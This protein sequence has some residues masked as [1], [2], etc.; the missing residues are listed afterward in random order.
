MNKL[1]FFLFLKGK[2]YLRAKTVLPASESPLKIKKYSD[3]SLHL[4]RGEDS[5]DLFH[6]RSEILT[7]FSILYMSLMDIYTLGRLFRN[8]KPPIT[9]SIVYVGQLHADIYNGFMRYMKY[10]K[11]IDLGSPDIV[12]DI[13]QFTPN[14]KKESFLFN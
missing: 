11:V 1:H 14:D 7:Q 8:F 3:F 6:Y 12:A 9:R 13:V 4:S 5:E 2:I 10:N